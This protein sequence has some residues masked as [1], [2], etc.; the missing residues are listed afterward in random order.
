[1]KKNSIKNIVI[2][3]FTFTLLAFHS[4]CKKFV[5][6]ELPRNEFSGDVVFQ[7]N[8]TALSAVTG[9]YSSMYASNGFANGSTN[10]VTQNS[11][12]SSDEFKNHS[13]TGGGGSVSFEFSANDI[14]VTNNT[15][16]G[17]WSRMYYNIFQTNLILEGLE[18]TTTVAE[19]VKKQLIGETKFLRAFCYYY[20]TNLYG[21]VPLALSS[22]YQGNNVLKRAPSSEVYSQ[23]ILDLKDAENLLS[24]PYP[25]T[26]RIRVNKLA[27]TALLARIYLHQGD[28]I[29]AENA[30]STVIANAM[31]SLPSNLDTVFK[32][33]SPEAIWQLLPNA[34]GRNTYEGSSF[35]LTSTPSGVSLSDKLVNAFEINDKRR[36]SWVGVFTNSTGTYYYPFKYKIR[37]NNLPV[38][39]YS[40]VLR[41]AEQYLIRAEAR[42]QQNKLTG[43]N[44]GQ[45]D[46]NAIR[47]R[48]G[49]PGVL[50]SDKNGLLLAV[51]Q[52]RFV[53][54]FS[55]WGHRWIDLKRTNR[56][57]AVLSVYKGASWQSS[58]I[59]Y[60]IPQ[61]ELIANPNLTQNKGY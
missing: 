30:A 42:I 20:L 4:S 28:W 35:I 61:S 18:A 36:Q 39:E 26:G 41:L 13:S 2:V 40:M 43:T 50:V 34:A 16:L 29:N 38:T 5:E 56:A 53:E 25:T 1:M 24:I 14:T 37:L 15:N 21:D 55:E 7:S 31:Y 9:V 49:L 19:S 57:D 44:S 45:S 17:L 47:A 23:I 10:S 27:A 51:E 48:A 33:T 11:G 6:V 58:D 54:F 3:T 32:S 8:A 46:V 60:P 22:N 52:E 59:L 12:R